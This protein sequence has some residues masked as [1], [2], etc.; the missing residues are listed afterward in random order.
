MKDGEITDEQITVS[1][2]YDDTYRKNNARLDRPSGDDGYGAW[3]P[4]TND[5]NQWIQVDLG[6]L[7]SVSGILLQGRSDSTHGDQWVTKYKVDYSNDGIT[8]QYI[9]DNYNDVDMVSK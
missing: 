1:S 3:V 9:K 2:E 8:W 7:K 6:T 5:V 4:K